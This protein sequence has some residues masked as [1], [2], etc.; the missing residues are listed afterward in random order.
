MVG[1]PPAHYLLLQT[2]TH[3]L[4]TD[5]FLLRESGLCDPLSPRGL[6]VRGP[7]NQHGPVA[8]GRGRR[9]M[10]IRGSDP[11]KRGLS[12]TQ[13][14]EPCLPPPRQSRLTQ[15]FPALVTPHSTWAQ[16][17]TVCKCVRPF[18]AREVSDT[19]LTTFTSAVIHR[20][21]D[22]DLCTPNFEGCL[23]NF[24]VPEDPARTQILTHW[25]RESA[26]LHSSKEMPT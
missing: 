24:H 2:F 7:G 6:R 19:D 23:S 20:G 18:V 4:S 11:W 12:H 1:M 10:G 3:G 5:Y 25:A 15:N 13:G 16:P 14:S 21:A 22:L 26:S 17:S 9:T 8:P